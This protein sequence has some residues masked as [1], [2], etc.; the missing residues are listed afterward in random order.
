MAQPDDCCETRGYTNSYPLT[1]VSEIAIESL[2]KFLHA[3]A[4][5]GERL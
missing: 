1:G 4:L 3:L 5:L 2:A